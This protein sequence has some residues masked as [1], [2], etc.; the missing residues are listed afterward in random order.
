MERRVDVDVR[1]V[2]TTYQVL[3]V[4][5]NLGE[6][7][8]TLLRLDF[9]S[10]SFPPAPDIHFWAD[11]TREQDPQPNEHTSTLIALH[12]A[13]LSPGYDWHLSA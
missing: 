6:A 1:G 10:V 13:I 7:N 2:Y 9:R 12:V 5:P 3:H 8:H 11:D 4:K